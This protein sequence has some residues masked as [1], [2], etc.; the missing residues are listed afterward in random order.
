VETSLLISKII[1]EN[2]NDP[3]IHKENSSKINT[4]FKSYG[5]GR[6]QQLINN[7]SE[8]LN[9]FRKISLSKFLN[10]SQYKSSEFQESKKEDE[11]TPIGDNSSPESVFQSLVNAAKSSDTRFLEGLCSKFKMNDKNT[12]CMCSYDLNY[13]KHNCNDSASI[14]PYSFR[15]FKIYFI[16]GKLIKPLKYVGNEALLVVSLGNIHNANI[17]MIKESGKWYLKSFKLK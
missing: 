14:W 7:N 4:L 17:L 10:L 9:K 6:K 13:Q 5:S 11:P 1:S 16:N 2:E 12:D 8:K 3:S 15:E